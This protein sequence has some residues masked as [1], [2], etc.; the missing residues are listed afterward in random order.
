MFD[1]CA[2][3]WQTFEESLHPRAF[4]LPPKLQDEVKHSDYRQF[5]FKIVR[6]QFAQDTETN[7]VHKF[8]RHCRQNLVSDAQSMVPP[9]AI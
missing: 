4:F 9:D 6:S 3:T 8:P 5:D 2:V 7:L 1:S